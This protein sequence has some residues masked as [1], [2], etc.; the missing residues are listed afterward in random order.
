MLDWI[1]NAISK[2]WGVIKKF[3]VKIIKLFESID[4]WFGSKYETVIKQ[5]PTAKPVAVKIDEAIQ[6]GKYASR[7]LENLGESKYKIVNTFYDPETK[8]ISEDYTEVIMSDDID[9]A[10]LE[11]FGDQDILIYE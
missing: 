8:T 11:A 5:N 2:I 7:S 9:E 3:F 6:T 4:N 1:Y 10:T